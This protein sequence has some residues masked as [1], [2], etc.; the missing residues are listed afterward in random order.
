[1]PV[2]QRT[3]VGSVSARQTSEEII[4]YSQ[5]LTGVNLW[6]NDITGYSLLS[7]LALCILLILFFRLA[8]LTQSYIR[9][10]A[11]IGSDRTR[12]RFWE[13]ESPTWSKIQKHL[14]IAPLLRSRHNRELHLVKNIKIG[15][16]PSRVH[17]LF[18]CFYACTNAIYCCLLD[19]HGQPR[20][21]LLAEI[22]GRTAHLAVINMIPLFL[23]C[24]RNNPL[25]WMFGITFDT[26]NLFHRW[27]GRILVIEVLAHTF[28]WGTNKFNAIGLEGLEDSLINDKFLLLGL[29]SSVSM[30]AI[31]FQS[32]SIFRH[33]I[34]EIFLHT[35]QFLALGAL[36][37]GFL[38]VQHHNLPQVPVF[39]FLMCLW[40]SERF[41]RI[42]RILRYNVSYRGI[43]KITVKA[44]DGG[45]CRVTFH[46]PRTFRPAPGSHLYAYIPRVSAHMSHPFSI[47]WTDAINPS[48]K[49]EGPTPV[50][51]G[52]SSPSGT[53]SPS[54]IRSITDGNQELDMDLRP[55]QRKGSN[56]SCVI[57]ANGGMTASLYRRASASP[58]GTITMTAFIEGPY[59]GAETLRSYGTV[60]LFAGGVGITHQLSLMKDLVDSSITGTC[61]TR[62][63]VLVWTV[64]KAEM[65]E[66]CSEWLQE[67]TIL[68]E[69]S[70]AEY[71]SGI[72]VKVL[73]YVTQQKGDDEKAI[74]LEK[75]RRWSMGT[76]IH[77]GRPNLKDIV[78]YEVRE[79]I[80]ALSIGV[81]G[82]G[83]L[84]DGVRQASRE[85]MGKGAKIDFWEES[86][87]W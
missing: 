25:I 77:Y 28:I 67:L 40:A 39:Y 59:G 21:A 17:T 73:L 10:L 45:A 7:S 31:F 80:G 8:L 60:L 82:P 47:A 34:Y 84:G 9:L 36:V 1:M 6:L 30:V 86:F 52:M 11:T 35:H 56:T 63:V 55:T 37:A 85:A 78:K 2:F 38:H 62:K 65:I 24:M 20:A 72:E 18:I 15:T 33:A 76:N 44:L 68:A 61:P 14:L 50:N 83:G 48:E 57:S 66:W 51:S 75:Q 13:Q 70:Q 87:T 19:Y 23:F 46:T 42:Y 58:M 81:C 5:G 16:I 12:L 79:R 29:I 69:S 54:G 3:T 43:T 27:I 4:P 41:L 53:R 74:A 64:K 49:L 71:G 22:R 26:F 32:P